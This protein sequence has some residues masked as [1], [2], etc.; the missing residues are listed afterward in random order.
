MWFV[1]KNRRRNDNEDGSE[2]DMVVIDEMLENLCV[3]R[4]LGTKKQHTHTQQ[5][6]NSLVGC[7]SGYLPDWFPLKANITCSDTCSFF[8]N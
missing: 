7:H 6:M 4:R 2:R 8:D 1:E 3:N 5:E